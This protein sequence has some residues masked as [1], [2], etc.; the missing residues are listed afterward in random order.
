MVSLY[1]QIYIL[2]D[3]F[4]HR[5]T[6]ECCPTANQGA[7]TQY[8]K[9]KRRTPGHGDDMQLTAWE[10]FKESGYMDTQTCHELFC[11]SLILHW[12]P[13]KAGDLEKNACFFLDTTSCL[14]NLLSFYI[15]ISLHRF[16]YRSPRF[17]KPSHVDLKI[18]QH[19][20]STPV[21]KKEFIDAE[22]LNSDGDGIFEDRFIKSLFGIFTHPTFDRKSF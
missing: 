6:V 12:I 4:S 7:A 18:Y 3:L 21:Q 5:R 1:I 15:Q 10:L 13:E 19:Y 2:N 9:I 22:I 14:S 8:I 17:A 16:T 11:E 20:F